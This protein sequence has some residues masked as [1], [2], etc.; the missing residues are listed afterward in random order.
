MWS[1][2]LLSEIHSNQNC[3]IGIKRLQLFLKYKKKSLKKNNLGKRSIALPPLTNGLALYNLIRTRGIGFTQKDVKA[4][5][6][7]SYQET[8]VLN[9]GM[10]FKESIEYHNWLCSHNIFFF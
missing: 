5:R 3:K 8:Q 2:K 7:V 9:Y 4:G 10:L 1:N 6:M